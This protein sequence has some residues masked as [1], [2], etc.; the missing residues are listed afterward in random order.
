MFNIGNFAVFQEKEMPNPSSFSCKAYSSLQSLL[1]QVFLLQFQAGYH[2]NFVSGPWS[3]RID[4][5]ESHLNF[6]SGPM[7]AFK[8]KILN[9][10]YFLYSCMLIV[11]L[12]Q[13][14]FVFYPTLKIILVVELVRVSS[15]HCCRKTAK[16]T[17]K[18]RS[19]SNCIM[20]L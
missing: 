13:H 16:I 15:M 14:I 4:P 3:L 12:K 6:F 19:Q 1:A 18:N 2:L 7:H 9:S 11:V 5:K 10:E 8:L 20:D 17:F